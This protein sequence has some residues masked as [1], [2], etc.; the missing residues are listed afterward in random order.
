MPSQRPRA[1]FEPISPELDVQ[2]LVDST[3]NFEF[4]VRFHCDAIDE[5]GLEKFDELVWRHVVQAGK[6]LVVEGFNERLDNSIFSENWLR[7]HY[8]KKGKSLYELFSL[9]HF[10]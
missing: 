10:L 3:P 7:T 9:W 6:P 4:V 2:A 8:G 1:A 5:Y